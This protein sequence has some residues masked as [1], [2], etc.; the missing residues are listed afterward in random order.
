MTKSN[1]Y[2]SSGSSKWYCP[3]HGSITSRDR[4][5]YSIIIF[6]KHIYIYSREKITEVF[7]RRSL[8]WKRFKLPKIRARFRADSP[9]T[10]S[11]VV[12]REIHLKNVALVIFARFPTSIV[13]RQ[14][15]RKIIL[16][17]MLPTFAVSRYY[18]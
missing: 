5:T 14:W 4:W 12:A 1:Q 16:V 8:E 9:P 18:Y 7:P 15:S 17:I 2:N 10:V 3:W 11:H 13:C 6:G